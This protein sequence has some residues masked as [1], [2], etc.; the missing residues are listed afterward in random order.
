MHQSEYISFLLQEYGLTDCNP[1]RLPA[2]PKAPLGDAADSYP[3]TPD[4]CH[5]YLKLV[6]EL[7]Y[8]AVNTRPDISYI[9]NALT[10]HN[11]HP[12]P[13]HL[14]AAKRVLRYLAGTINL[15]MY[16]EHDG[17]NEGLHTYAD[18]SWANEVGRRSVTGYTW[19]Y[20]GCLISHVSKKQATVA[21]S[22]TEAEYM[23]TTHVIQ[24]GLWLRSLL[25]ELSVPFSIPV[26]MYLDNSGAIALS[27]AAKFH[28]HSKH[29][30]I[31]YHFI[32]EHV[33]NAIFSLVW[34][35]SHRNITDILTKALAKPAFEG[36]RCALGL[37]AQ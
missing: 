25:T 17:T 30:N 11:A 10:Q 21:L 31:R 16:Y 24:E 12:E 18:A 23:A 15:R 14:A 35:P 8:L 1:A 28:Q 22:S 36:F 20:A 9:V 2:D 33:D 32:H 6:G 4:L 13:H 37:V 7:I 34:L 27:S 26:P 5:A 29:I 3:E 19:Y